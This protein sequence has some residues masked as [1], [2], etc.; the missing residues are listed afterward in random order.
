MI[1]LQNDEKPEDS[2][3]R[4]EQGSARSIFLRLGGFAALPLLSSLAPLLLLPIIARVGGVEGWASV[5]TAQAIGAFGSVMVSFGWTIAGPPRITREKTD[6]ERRRLYRSAFSTRVVM[7]F[8]FAPILMAVSA[9]LA[10]PAHI[11]DA[12]VMTG[13]MT[14]F[15]LSPAWYCIGLG[16]PRLIATFEAIPKFLATL[17][18]AAFLLIGYPIWTYPAVLILAT[19][20]G[21][22]AFHTT[23]IE[24]WWPWTKQGAKSVRR[25]LHTMMIPALVEITGSTY[26]AMPVPIASATTSLLSTGMFASADKLF[27]YGMFSISALAN[28]LQAWVLEGAI[29]ISRR[30]HFIAIAAHAVLGLVGL[31][32]LVVA[33]PWATA[34]LFGD[35]VKAT[36]DVCIW[37]GIA[38]LFLSLTTPLI[39]NLL[40]PN[41]KTA[42]ILTATIISAVVGIPTMIISGISLGSVGVAFGFALSETLILVSILPESIRQ[43][44]RVCRA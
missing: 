3:R 44:Q 28:A 20:L 14:L 33:G 42:V 7:M 9:V 1:D 21:L 19:V 41:G 18:A 24:S 34:L 32:V 25:T 38:F 2:K 16:R 15:G 37:Y 40:I 22:V 27:R 30:R 39:R 10:S 4:P 26:A 6:V 29:G 23:Q 13:A 12:V 5:A 43:M 36:V 11:L 8:V 35:P 17:V 31:A